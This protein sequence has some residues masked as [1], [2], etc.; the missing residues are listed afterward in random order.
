[1][2]YFVVSLIYDVPAKAI[3]LSEG[4]HDKQHPSSFDCAS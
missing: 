2:T 4:S 3:Y 1:M